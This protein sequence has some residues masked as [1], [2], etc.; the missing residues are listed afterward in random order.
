MEGTHWSKVEIIMRAKTLM[1]LAQHR[2]VG[3]N[4]GEECSGC[5][6]PSE[7]YCPPVLKIHYTNNIWFWGLLPSWADFVPCTPWTKSWICPWVGLRLWIKFEGY[8]KITTILD[9]LQTSSI[10]Q[11]AVELSEFAE[12]WLSQYYHTGL[13]TQD[14]C[15]FIYNRLVDA[16][17]ARQ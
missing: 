7:Q 5:A 4:P 15:C 8:F 6:P 12:Y 3:V 1:N 16:L 13:P 9:I 14:L 17:K 11:Q 2:G 10:S